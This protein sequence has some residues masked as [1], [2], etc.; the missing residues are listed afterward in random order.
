[1][2]CV[3]D[4]IVTKNFFYLMSQ[5][6]S[7]Y[8]FSSLPKWKDKV[9]QCM[10][11]L[12]SFFYSGETLIAL[13]LQRLPLTPTIQAPLEIVTGLSL[14]VTTCLGNFPLKHSTLPH[15]HNKM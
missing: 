5:V 12:C 10:G 8:Q 9:C 3:T 14:H 13:N 2:L 7:C 6:N 15:S 1:M 4:N 11:T